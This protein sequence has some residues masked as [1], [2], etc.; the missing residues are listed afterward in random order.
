MRVC[1]GEPRERRVWKRLWSENGNQTKK[2]NCHM[3]RERTRCFEDPHLLVVITE[4]SSY[5]CISKN[6]TEIGSYIR[7]S[8]NFTWL[9]IY[10]FLKSWSLSMW[11][12]TNGR[13]NKWES[14]SDWL[15]FWDSWEMHY[16]VCRIPWKCYLSDFAV[17]LALTSS[18]FYRPFG[19]CQLAKQKLLI[20]MENQDCRPELEWI[21]IYF[22]QLFNLVFF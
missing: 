15:V 9:M 11:M 12:G 7:I 8:R 6:I 21:S 4:I 3:S 13:G 14:S 20:P 16:A 5:I 17:T 2:H 1:L 19:R 18:H 10:L 22:F